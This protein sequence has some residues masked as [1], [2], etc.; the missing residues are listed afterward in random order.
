MNIASKIIQRAL[1]SNAKWLTF[2][3][4]IIV[5]IAL[6][7]FLARKLTSDVKLVA[8]AAL[9]VNVISRYWNTFKRTH[10]RTI[11]NMKR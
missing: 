4:K 5:R 11:R 1:V 8:M 6:L 10:E 3:L 2:E 7:W 9:A